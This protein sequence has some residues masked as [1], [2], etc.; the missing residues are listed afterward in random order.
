MKQALSFQAK[1][2]TQNDRNMEYD[3]TGDITPA[4]QNNHEVNLTGCWLTSK[5]KDKSRSPCNKYLGW[6][7]VILTKYQ[8]IGCSIKQQHKVPMNIAAITPKQDP[9]MFVG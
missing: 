5:Y 7:L 6:M 3:F 9:H 4:H 8:R 2:H 1:Q